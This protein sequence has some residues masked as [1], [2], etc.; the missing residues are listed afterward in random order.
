MNSRRHFG[1]FYT[2]NFVWSLPKFCISLPAHFLNQISNQMNPKIQKAIYYTATTLLTVLMLFSSVMY[3]INHEMV[4][5]AFTK[6]G[7][8]TYLIYPLAMAKVLGLIA[9]WTNFSPLLKQWAYAGFFFDCLLAMSAHLMV[10]DGEF[11]AAMMGLIFVIT[12][13]TFNER[14]KTA[15]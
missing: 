7:Y 11:Q 8:P 14:L 4:V 9:I 15:S 12:S 6:L 3:V 2:M 13:A 1:N 5:E 10:Q